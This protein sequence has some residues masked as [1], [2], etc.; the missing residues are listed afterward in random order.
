MTIPGQGLSRAV[1]SGDG[2]LL[3]MQAGEPCTG[4]PGQVYGVGDRAKEPADEG[5]NP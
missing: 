3:D 4:R 5:R 2:N 1:R